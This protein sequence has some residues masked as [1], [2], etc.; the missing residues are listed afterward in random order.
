MKSWEI[1]SEIDRAERSCCRT[2]RSEKKRRR[3][4]PPKP[5][6]P[7]KSDFICGDLTPRTII[8]RLFHTGLAAGPAPLPRVAPFDEAFQHVKFRLIRNNESA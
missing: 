8:R 1:G 7:L 3:K 5:P 4:K 6:S 2:V